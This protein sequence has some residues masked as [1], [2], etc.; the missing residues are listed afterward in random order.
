MATY[1]SVNKKRAKNWLLNAIRYRWMKT[2]KEM[3]DPNLWLFSAWEGEKYADNTK[4]FFEYILKKHTE[5]KCIWQTRNVDVFR[6]LKKDGKPVQLIGTKEA[7]STQRRAGAVFYTNGLDDFGDFPLVY[8]SVIVS[9]WHGVGFK[10]IYREL[11]LPKNGFVRLYSNAKWDFFSWVKRD[12][13]IA[14]SKGSERQ[15]RDGFLLKDKDLVIIAGQPRN[16]IFSEKVFVQDILK[17][18]DILK[19]I[20]NKCVI[21]YMPTFRKD[22]KTLIEQLKILWQS[23]SFEKILADNNAVLLTKLHYLNRGEL[24]STECKILINDADVI[25]S[26]KLMCCV[27]ILMTDYSSCAI[28]FALQKKPILFYFP[29][30]T[31]YDANTC[32]IEGTR[33]VCSINCADTLQELESKVQETLRFP[34]RGMQQTEM[35]NQLFDGTAVSPGRYSENVYKKIIEYISFKTYPSQ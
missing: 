28:D 1:N 17:N 10:K 24:K 13:T 26:Q 16:D 22:A 8:G 11:Y 14:T 25:D 4:Y 12:I 29:D 27:D 15:F 20:K 21:L 33:E 19:K 31:E 7:K 18:S 3:R 6:M 2:F 34:Q 9:L 32:M 30:W 23:E 35:L 5:I